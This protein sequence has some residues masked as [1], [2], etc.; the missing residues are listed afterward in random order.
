MNKK[1]LSMSLMLSALTAFAVTPSFAGGHGEAA[2]HGGSLLDNRPLNSYCR[3]CHVKEDFP[4][5][6]QPNLLDTCPRLG[7]NFTGQYE[8]S[9]G[10]DTVTIDQL[11]NIYGPVEFDHIGHAKWCELG[12][13]C[14]DCHHVDPNGVITSCGECHESSP[15]REDMRVPSLKAVYHLNCM[16]CHLEWGH[17]NACQY[18]HGIAGRD[19]DKS[20]L[21]HKK[22]EA[23]NAYVFKSDHV[24]GVVTFDHKGHSGMYGQCAAC[25]SGGSCKDC[26]DVTKQPS[27]E[28]A[29]LDFGTTCGSCHAGN[30]AKVGA[31]K[32]ASTGLALGEEHVE[33][34]CSDC[35]TNRNF[36]VKSC[37]DCHD[38]EFSHPNDLPGEKVQ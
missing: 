17:K 36:A 32:H 34:E 20:S 9:D 1:T 15:V 25:H 16:G 28:S 14:V 33:L 26:H 37:V 12:N 6:N 27:A 38:D 3:T 2:V 13:G 4:T 11:A 19:A 23:Q 18:C 5:D 29:L 22:V 31:F 8:L 10:P 35:H 24:G 30:A 7:G 21:A